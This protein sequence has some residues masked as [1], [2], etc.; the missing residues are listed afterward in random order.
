MTREE[1][2]ELMNEYLM[3]YV[4]PQYNAVSVAEG[5]FNKLS[6]HLDFDFN[7]DEKMYADMEEHDNT[8]DDDSEAQGDE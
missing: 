3:D 4:D 7:E 6:E 5:L 1:F 2:V 8:F